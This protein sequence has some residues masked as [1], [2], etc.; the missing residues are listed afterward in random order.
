MLPLSPSRGA[1]RN[2]PSRL[3]LLSSKHGRKQPPS[4]AHFLSSAMALQSW[5][6]LCCWR[7]SGDLD[8]PAV[9]PQCRALGRLPQRR[10]SQAGC[11]AHVAA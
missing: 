7:R 3:V 1:L 2:K 9:W 6:V 5:A 11:P 4:A 10:P 8:P